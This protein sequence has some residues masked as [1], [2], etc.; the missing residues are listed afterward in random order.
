MC[1]HDVFLTDALTRMGVIVIAQEFGIND[2][3]QT[4]TPLEIVQMMKG[5]TTVGDHMR[6]K[7]METLHIAPPTRSVCRGHVIRSV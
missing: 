2:T 5:I 3:N 6:Q 7:V 1:T 4:D